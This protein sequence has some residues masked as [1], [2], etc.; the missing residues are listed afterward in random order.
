MSST[1]SSPLQPAPDEALTAAE[2]LQLTEEAHDLE[3]LRR[4]LS[5]Q[6]QQRLDELSQSLADM[7]QLIA[8]KDALAA[9]IAPTLE[10][11]LREQIQQNRAEMVELFSP[12]IGQVV[13]R[14]VTEAIQDLARS[15]DARVRTTITPLVALRRARGLATGVSDGE[16]ALRE[17]LPFEV[18]EVFLI[19]RT[20]GLLLRHISM[21]EES[22]PDRD[23]VSG[24]FTAVRD[25]VADAFGRE[26]TS[27]LEMIE[28]GERRILIEAAEHVYLAVVVLG[29]EPPG[30]RSVMRDL[31]FMIEQRYRFLL[32]NYQGD[33]SPFA[34]VDV[35]IS[36]LRG[37]REIE[38]SPKSPVLTRRQK[39]I[40][41]LIAS[42]LLLCLVVACWSSI[43]T[44]SSIRHLQHDM[45]A[46][47]SA[48]PPP[49]LPVAL[50]AFTATPTPTVTASPTATATPFPTSTPT[51]SVT[52]TASASPVPTSSSTALPRVLITAERL[53][54][55][56]GP[57]LDY[58]IKG[59]V[60]QGMQFSVER[61][62]PDASWLNVCCLSDNSTGWLMANY[63]KFT[64]Q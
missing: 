51:A 55:R 28:Y 10:T 27:E 16:M 8:N 3:T 50:P 59:I 44:V 24:M 52:P 58:P 62:S 33:A 9:F 48:S 20:T 19:H 30:Y 61:S 11:A 57:G 17:A 25:F 13:L 22:P 53:N 46:V 5:G 40:A 54:V 37:E 35:S 49:A 1:S 64:E 4:I 12:I 63:T 31:I 60:L 14:A 42:S 29:V 26:Q 45:Q 36:S 34:E 6:T 56:T 21:H 23:L 18:S 39:L 43:W 41:A 7:Q 15:V 2:A 38:T 32:R 47:H